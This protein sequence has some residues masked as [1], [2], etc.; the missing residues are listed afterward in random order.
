MFRFRTGFRKLT[1]SWLYNG[2]GELVLYSLMKILDAFDTRVREG[3]EAKF[4][5]RTSEDGLD[6]LGSDREVLRGRDEN[7]ESYAQR[8]IEWR[9]PRGHRVRGSAFAILTQ[10][11]A[12]F[13]GVRCW[14]IDQNGNRHD[15][16]L[17]GTE[18]YS[19]GNA[20][21]WD[22][23]PTTPNWARFWIV[24][25]ASTTDGISEPPTWDDPDLWGGRTYDQAAAAGF[26]ID[27]NGVS[28]QDVKA[29]RDLFTGRA[30]NPSGTLPEWVVITFDGSDPVPDGTWDTAAGRDASGYGFWKL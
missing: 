6:R 10:V 3:H 20:W 24:I 30:W 15:R 11:S 27:C 7:R 18:S 22:G 17:D 9:Y 4:P 21:N 28:A 14:T 26:T 29:I 12:Y 25:D 5:T 1:P 19:Y 16:A 23:A 13:G 2:E 8:L